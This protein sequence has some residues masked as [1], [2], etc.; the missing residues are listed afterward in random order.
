MS[1]LR[2]SDTDFTFLIP[3]FLAEG[4]G[5]EGSR[6]CCRQQITAGYLFQP[7]DRWTTRSGKCFRKNARR[8]GTAQLRCARAAVQNRI[9]PL[10]RPAFLCYTTRAI[11]RQLLRSDRRRPDRLFKPQFDPGHT[12]QD[13][14]H[15]EW[16]RGSRRRI[17]CPRLRMID[18]RAGFNGHSRTKYT[19]EEALC[20]RHAEG[21]APLREYRPR[22]ANRVF[23]A[24]SA[25][26]RC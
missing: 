25:E 5:F 7:G 11:S 15:R 17:C 18:R 12:P 23:L 3:S 19:V 9:L 2:T 13:S 10:M 21:V 14:A 24:I 1:V 4:S 6:S 8:A 16:P 20:A 22:L 26:S